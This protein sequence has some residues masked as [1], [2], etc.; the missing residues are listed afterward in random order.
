M[1]FLK[2]VL[3]GF[4]LLYLNHLLSQGVNDQYQFI[5]IKEGIPKIGV[6]TITQDDFGFIWIGTNGAGIYKYNG[7]DFNEYKASLRDSTSISSSL[8]YCSIVDNQKRLWIGTEEGLN[9]YQKDKD[10]FKKINI[11]ANENNEN[12]VTIAGLQTDNKGN[13]FVGSF[14][15]GMFKINLKTLKSE[16]ILSQKETETSSISVYN[17]ILDKKENLYVTTN[18]GLK[19]YDYNTNTLKQAKFSNNN[20]L[21][22]I[23]HP[24]KTI[25][26]DKNNVIWI[27][28]FNHGMYRIEETDSFNEE[29]KIENFKISNNPIL[30][31]ISLPDNTIM[32]GTENNG[33]FHLK[34]NG[35]I[36]KNYLQNKTDEKS[37]LSNSIWSLFVDKDNRIWVG[38]YNK[39]VVVY[40]KLYDKFKDFESLTNNKNSLQSSS[41]TAISKDK[42]GKLWIGM[43]GGGIDI[44]NEKT[45][46]FTHINTTSN[47]TYKGLTSDYIETVFISFLRNYLAIVLAIY[48]VI[49]FYT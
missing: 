37:I 21:T 31:I 45:N 38:Y 9:L 29:F 26:K 49:E 32:C 36:I 24:V 43:D 39:G 42:N 19:T 25:I 7:I 34:S 4:F 40:N 18:K 23:E 27:G 2:N 6:S 14:G 3:I 20:S 1:K 46:E 48:L 33:L 17:F 13:L 41:V 44:L 30:A 12:N 11:L 10:Q 16:K 8:I 28:T 35:E 5:K 47:S 22:S 15:Q